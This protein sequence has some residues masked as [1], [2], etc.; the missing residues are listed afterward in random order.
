MDN[1][2]LLVVVLIFVVSVVVGYIRRLLKIGLSLL[3]TVITMVIVVF[4]SP[5]VGDALLKYTPIDE[6][7]EENCM[8]G[9][10]ANRSGDMLLE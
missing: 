7:I 4:L 10:A 9:F 6:M 2:V 5:Y 8:E 1:M 3:S